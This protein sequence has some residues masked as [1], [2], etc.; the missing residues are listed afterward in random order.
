MFKVAA[1]AQASAVSSQG[2]PGVPTVNA[3][4]AP[5]SFDTAQQTRLESTPPLSSV[6]TGTSAAS[7]FSTAR[8]NN[9]SVSSTAS[10]NVGAPEVEIAGGAQYSRA[11]SSP[12]DHST[13]VA[14]GTLV[15]P[16]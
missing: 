3:L 14:A 6:P 4:M 10:S 1:V 2:S 7:R 15:R 8:R 12:P 9:R 11:L 13:I 5:P 16:L